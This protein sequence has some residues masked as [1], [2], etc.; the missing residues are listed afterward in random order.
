MMTRVRVMKGVRV[1]TGV[2]VKP[3]GTV[4]ILHVMSISNK[5]YL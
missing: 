2:S 1:M 4:L 5:R 3:P